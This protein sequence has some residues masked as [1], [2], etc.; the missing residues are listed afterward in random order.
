[1]RAEISGGDRTIGS[2]QPLT[3]SACAGTMQPGA[4]GARC[5]ASEA[6][7]ALR[8]EWSCTAADGGSCAVGGAVERRCAWR[9]AAGALAAGRVYLFSVRV[10]VLGGDWAASA[11]A[12]ISVSSS[13]A[14]L[15]DVDVVPV[16]SGAHS[17]D[18][19]LVLRGAAPAPP[20]GSAPAL[21][22]SVLPSLALSSTTVASTG[23]H[24]PRL[25]C[26][27]PP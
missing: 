22:W 18:A 5:D 17:S 23:A 2:Q 27:P 8:F 6:C 24:G 11:S 21:S 16:A 7:G 10:K 9:L 4:E 1:M 3:L 19:R 26:C 13:A 12:A 20:N 15:P 25:C 14:L